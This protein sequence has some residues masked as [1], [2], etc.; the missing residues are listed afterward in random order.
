MPAGTGGDFRKTIGLSTSPR[1]AAKQLRDGRTKTIDLGRVTFTAKDG[2][3]DTRYF[4][5]VASFGLSASINARVKEKGSLQWIPNETIRGKTKF[6]VSTIQEI[7]GN[8]FL[9]IRVSIDGQEE[10]MLNTI[11]F[12]VCN[13]RFFGGGMKIAPN[14]KLGDGLF[15]IVNIGDINTAKI[16]LNGYKLYNGTHLSL[17]E[18]KSRQGGKV[19]VAPENAGDI[20]E[21]ETD[22]E[23]PG[24]L[25]AMFEIVPNALRIRVPKKL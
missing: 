12:C 14:A 25:P 5:N 22:G 18:V 20:V 21:I 16:M 15:D 24:Y 3:E 11:N 13:G 6:A 17:N 1:E 9:T 4:V 2:H 10:Q 19:F 23:L 8:D 7:L